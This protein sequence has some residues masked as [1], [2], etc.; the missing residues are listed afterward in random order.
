[1]YGKLCTSP[2]ASFHHISFEESREACQALGARIPGVFELNNKVLVTKARIWSSTRC[3]FHHRKEMGYVV[4]SMTS[5][6]EHLE[7]LLSNQRISVQCV[8]DKGRPCKVS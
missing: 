8:A 7:C 3:S 1:M 5:R 6:G 2:R 4:R